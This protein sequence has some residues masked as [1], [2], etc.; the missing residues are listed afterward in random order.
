MDNGSKHKQGN[1]EK[2]FLPQSIV[3]SSHVDMF[4]V[5]V[6]RFFQINLSV[7]IATVGSSTNK[8]LSP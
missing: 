1:L 7:N 6:H 2:T 3:S 5:L 8:K 4:L